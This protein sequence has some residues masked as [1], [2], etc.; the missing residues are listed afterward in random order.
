MVGHALRLEFGAAGTVVTGLALGWNVRTH[1]IMFGFL[2]FC[3][4]TVYT[5][6]VGWGPCHD[7]G[8]SPFE[9]AL[10]VLHCTAPFCAQSLCCGCLT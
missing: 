2:W 10:L 4:F 1:V 8:A 7:G 9:R 3:A 5:Y 6:C